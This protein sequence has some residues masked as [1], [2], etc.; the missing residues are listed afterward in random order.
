[1]GPQ[2]NSPEGHAATP[3][4][5]PLAPRLACGRAW[6]ETSYFRMALDCWFVKYYY[7]VV[8]D[9]NDWRSTFEWKIRRKRKKRKN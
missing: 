5:V 9:S 3:A 2:E 8:L 1:M 7:D 4:A 6:I